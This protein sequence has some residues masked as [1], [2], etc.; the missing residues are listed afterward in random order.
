MNSK[1]SQK[2]QPSGGS[3]KYFIG[4]HKDLVMVE[5]SPAESFVDFVHRYIKN[6]ARMKMDQISFLSMD[7]PNQMD[8]LS[9]PFVIPA[10]FGRGPCVREIKSA[11]GCNLII[12]AT[13]SQSDSSRF[14]ENRG[15]LLNLLKP[16][17]NAVYRSPFSTTF[18]RQFIIVVAY[19]NIPIERY[20]YAVIKIAKQLGLTALQEECFNPLA[21]FPLPVL[22][23]QDGVS[24][25]NQV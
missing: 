15:E 13:A 12:L 10:A 5:E 20:P 21:A 14:Y 23:G 4:K 6:P 2:V 7:S 11:I 8:A 1:F 17:Q 24:I 25:S 19:D 18:A 16:W 22:F 3:K 9:S